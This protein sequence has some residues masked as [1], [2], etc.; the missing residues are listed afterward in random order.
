MEERAGADIDG[1]LN[2]L[3]VKLFK[4]IMEIEE[5]YLI[6]PKFKEIS[7]NDMHILEA[8]G[9]KEAKSMSTVAKLVSVT[10]GTLTKSVDALFGKGYV[11]RERG[12]KDKRLVFVSL[13]EKGKE[14][15]HHHETFHRNMIAHIKDGMSEQ[16]MPMIVYALAKMNDYFY[17]IY[18]R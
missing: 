1:T 16:E 14:A 10:T 5:K 13:T 2:E 3:L 9:L 12:Q 17:K 8:I 6:T 15:Y 7:V 18:E 11:T 4:N